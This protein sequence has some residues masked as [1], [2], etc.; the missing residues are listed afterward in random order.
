[1]K[2][3]GRV[4]IYS[5]LVMALLLPAFFGSCTLLD[6]IL[7]VTAKERI[8]RFNNDLTAGN[9][10]ELY[11]H[12][13]KTET[14]QYENIRSAAYWDTTPFAADYSPKITN[15]GDPVEGASAVTVSA[16]LESS[17]D[18]QITFTLKPIDTI[19]YIEVV[20]F[21]DDS[22]DIRLLTDR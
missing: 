10:T 15:I 4:K 11:K 18:Y 17:Q 21:S 1:M 20:D 14:D 3:T 6:G 22:F 16:V 12:F 2:K 5:A 13:H 19:Y 8:N 9:Y 7:G